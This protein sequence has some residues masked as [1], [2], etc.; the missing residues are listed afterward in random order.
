MSWIREAEDEARRRAEEGDKARK[1]TATN[2]AA[3]DSEP[4]PTE[5][6][7]AE[8]LTTH[9]TP[10]LRVIADLEEAGYT[11]KESDPEYLYDSDLPSRNVRDLGNYTLVKAK[12]AW[13]GLHDEVEHP[14]KAVF[15]INWQIRM[16]ERS[17]GSIRMYPMASERTHLGSVDY[18]ESPL[19]YGEGHAAVASST[20][21]PDVIVEKLQGAISAMIRQNAPQPT[22]V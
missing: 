5:E 19:R 8:F 9:K 2:K 1:I 17:I 6:E 7:V 16:G 10:V 4:E 13:G 14:Y 21:E 20:E 3:F 11:V 22:A 15:G 12:S 18:L